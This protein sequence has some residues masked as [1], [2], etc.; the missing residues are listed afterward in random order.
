[1]KFGFLSKYIP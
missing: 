1:M